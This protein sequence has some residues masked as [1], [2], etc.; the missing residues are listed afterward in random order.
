MVCLITT[1]LLLQYHY[2]NVSVGTEVRSNKVRHLVCFVQDLFI[3]LFSAKQATKHRIH[4]TC[5][6]CQTGTTAQLLLTFDIY[7]LSQYQQCYG[8][9]SAAVSPVSLHMK[10]YMFLRCC[11]HCVWLHHTS[12]LT[13]A[14]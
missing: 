12:S 2:S 9:T 8:T 11:L 7:F 4:D 13:V 3:L 10:L 1:T 5:R 14:Q 6:C